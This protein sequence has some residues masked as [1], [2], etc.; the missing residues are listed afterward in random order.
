MVKFKYFAWKDQD[1]ANKFLEE[2][3]Y[4]V[5][6]EDN[7]SGLKQVPDGI[8]IWYEDGIYNWTHSIQRAEALIVTSMANIEYHGGQ[9]EN[10]KRILKRLIPKGF[11]KEL[12]HNEV[13][14][15]LKSE[16]LTHDQAKERLDAIVQEENNQLSSAV[17]IENLKEDIDRYE[18]DIQR[19]ELLRDE[20]K[21]LK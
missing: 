3:S 11:K 1:K 5:S 14:N 21:K 15:L 18:R 7:F 17:S 16:G 10:S 6:K 4:V 12:D 13:I 19:Y 8:V 20:Q 9:I 2:R